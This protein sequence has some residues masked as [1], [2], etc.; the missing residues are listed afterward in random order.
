[1]HELPAAAQCTSE[2]V[3][4]V[5]WTARCPP[6]ADPEACLTP[7]ALGQF[8]FF[9]LLL[10][11]LFLVEWIYFSKRKTFDKRADVSDFFSLIFVA[12]MCV[13]LHVQ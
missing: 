11:L 9:L 5:T 12:K 6:S 3:G 7:H 4:V 2:A 13:L 8:F 1:M 10:L